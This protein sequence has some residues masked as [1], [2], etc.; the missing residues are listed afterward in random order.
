M[1]L[2][3]NKRPMLMLALLP[4]WFHTIS[5]EIAVRMKIT[6]QIMPITLPCGVH[7]GSLRVVYQFIPDSVSLLPISATR[8][9]NRG[10]TRLYIN[11]MVRLRSR[12]FGVK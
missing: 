10:M 4:Y 9:V 7:L 3:M 5:A 11:F 8:R 6:V 12:V 1:P 2:S